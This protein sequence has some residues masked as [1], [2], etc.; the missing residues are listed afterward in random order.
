M[1]FLA[2]KPNL[3]FTE[4]HGAHIFYW[5]RIPF[6]ILFFYFAADC[7]QLQTTAFSSI[8]SEKHWVA[9]SEKNK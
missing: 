3:L 7:I 5:I 9:I 2:V 6:F 8:S 1:W 4:S